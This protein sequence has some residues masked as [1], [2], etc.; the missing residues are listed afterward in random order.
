MTK[1]N[2]VLEVCKLS[3]L[4]KASLDFDNILG[5][6][7]SCE[8]FIGR[9]IDGYGTFLLQTVIGD[10]ELPEKQFETYWNTCLCGGPYD[11]E[12]AENLYEELMRL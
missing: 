5:C 12:V 7:A 1:E 4:I 8:G 11:D 9:L 6:D 2:F 10:K 3:D